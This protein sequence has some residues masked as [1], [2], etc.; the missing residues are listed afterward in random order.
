MIKMNK[1]E[2]IKVDHLSINGKERNINE[3]NANVVSEKIK[4][5]SPIHKNINRNGNE[6]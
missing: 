3:S 1:P 6:K 2:N 4:V 5:V